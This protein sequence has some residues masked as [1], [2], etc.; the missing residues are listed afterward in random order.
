MVYDPCVFAQKYTERYCNN[1]Y[2]HARVLKFIR[3]R[4]R[5]DESSLFKLK[6]REHDKYA[7]SVNESQLIFCD[8]NFHG[9]LNTA[10]RYLLYSLLL[11][12]VNTAKYSALLMK[13]RFQFFAKK[14]LKATY[15]YIAAFQYFFRRENAPV[16]YAHLF[17][18][19]GAYE[20]RAA[21]P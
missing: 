3:A 10:V 4:A 12:C 16:R 13:C 17:T 5:Y 11:K 19:L 1:K 14:Y 7:R 18:R 20:P 15:V 6:R 2:V 9:G 21:E 8:L